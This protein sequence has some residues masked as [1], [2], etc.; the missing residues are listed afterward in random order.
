MLKT[1]YDSYL[2][3]SKVYSY[4]AFLKQSLSDTYIEEINRAKT[5]KICYGVLEN[6]LLLEYYISRFCDKRPK[7][8]IRIILKIAM[9][10]IKFLNSHSYAVVDNAVELL[11]KMGK[12]GSSGFVNAVLR[13]FIVTDITLPED[14]ISNLSIKYSYPEFAV[15][16]LISDYG[17]K[18]A[19]DI[20]EHR[21]E[22]TFVRFNNGVD[23][24]KYLKN[25]EFEYDFT[26]FYN[27]FSVNNFKR[28]ED[29]DKG[30]YTFQSIG[31][32]AICSLVGNGEN[33]MDACA[34]P[35]GK[36]VFLADYFKNVV[37]CEFHS[38]RANLIKSYSQRMGKDN[39]T[40]YNLDSSVYNPDFENSFDAVLV[41][42]PC[43]G[44]GVVGEN[45]DIK[46]KRSEEDIYR[47]TEIQFDIL[48]NVSKYVKKGG[49][50]CYST[51]SVF[52][53]ENEMVCKKFIEENSNFDAVS[54][55][56]KLNHIICNPGIA[57][58]PHISE[59]A[60]FYFCKMVKLC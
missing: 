26:P 43:S 25:A 39:I 14:K 13:K 17:Y 54:V 12:G 53:I 57:F 49:V 50:L 2:V 41:D 8:A 46:I 45:P 22:K 29:Y 51:C 28:N 56:S 59:G 31:S 7:T 5:T 60:G 35:G 33:L 37:S 34:A 52:K 58:L 38:H 27:L 47:L 23:G 6:D 9:F 44:F 36:S 19:V 40:V 48:K 42:A 24:E 4:G 21:K 30:L 1:F 10:S 15:K 32:V 11:K 18:T 55:E 20:I 3:L 16:H